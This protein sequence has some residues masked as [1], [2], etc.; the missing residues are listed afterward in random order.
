MILSLNSYNF[1]LFP[2]CAIQKARLLCNVSASNLEA[3]QEQEEDQKAE[4]PIESQL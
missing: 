2:D 3:V 4:E 1:S